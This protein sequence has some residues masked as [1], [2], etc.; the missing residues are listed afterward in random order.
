[1]SN[2][3]QT[4]SINFNWGG[5]DIASTT[6]PSSSSPIGNSQVSRF[7]VAIQQQQQ[8]H[9]HEPSIIQMNESTSAT[10]ATTTTTNNNNTAEERDPLISPL[11]L[12]PYE[13]WIKILSY[14]GKFKDLSM[15]G[16]ASHLC[17]IL[18][19]DNGLWKERW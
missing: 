18:A 14:V 4:D 6:N 19:N 3:Q 5:D 8:Q 17:Y 2:R 7:Q 11:R 15:F 12:L 16:S 1:M 9:E 13:I 10:T